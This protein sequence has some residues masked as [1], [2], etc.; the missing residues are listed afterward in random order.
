ML[1]S[2]WV[3]LIYG[4]YLVRSGWVNI[5]YYLVWRGWVNIIYYLVRISWVNII[6]YLIRS[7]WVNKEFGC[8]IL[9]VVFV[10]S[11]V[12]YFCINCL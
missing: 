6:Y 7:S 2:S 4:Y 8:Y 9:Y 3:S 11:D 12:W 5:I 1:F 10:V